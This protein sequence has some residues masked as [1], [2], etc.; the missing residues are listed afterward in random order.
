MTDTTGKQYLASDAANEH[1]AKTLP[2][3]PQPTLW[4][5]HGGPAFPANMLPNVTYKGMSLRDYFAG[6]ALAG[7]V[8]NPDP[9]EADDFMEAARVL[10]ES[11]YQYADAMLAARSKSS[12]KE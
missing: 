3:H 4:D 8:A 12:S 2:P 9:V 1:Y 7:I 6:Q 11:S 10:A 5:D